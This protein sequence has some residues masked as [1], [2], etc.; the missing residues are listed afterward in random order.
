MYVHAKYVF[1]K[2]VNRFF[3]KINP[4]TKIV[5][6]MSENLHKICIYYLSVCSVPPFSILDKDKSPGQNQQ[7][8]IYPSCWFSSID[9]TDFCFEAKN[10]YLLMYM[11][12][13]SSN[14]MK[15]YTKWIEH[16]IGTNNYS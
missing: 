3:C 11:A 13:S 14:A 5:L 16:I 4:H 7:N 15:S 8:G 1:T 6:F 12:V 9:F 10:T 2:C